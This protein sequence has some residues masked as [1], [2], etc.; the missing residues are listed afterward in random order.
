ML[1]KGDVKLRDLDTGLQTAVGIRLRQLGDLLPAAQ[2]FLMLSLLGKQ[3]GQLRQHP[4]IVGKELGHAG[5]CLQCFGRLPLTDPDPAQ[6][7]V[8]VEQLNPRRSNTSPNSS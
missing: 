4:L 6:L 2:C 1:A 8:H 5:P 7:L 3:L